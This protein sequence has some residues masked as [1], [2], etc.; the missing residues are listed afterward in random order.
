MYIDLLLFINRIFEK[1]KMI[2]IFCV[3]ELI[4]ECLLDFCDY[5]S[6]R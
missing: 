4:V 6:F 5:D 2:I 1:L 3:Y